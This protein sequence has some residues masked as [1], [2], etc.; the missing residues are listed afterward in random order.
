MRP[1]LPTL[2]LSMLTATATAEP[3]L[4]IY[5]ADGDALFAPGTAAL[6]EGH[7]IAHET[8]ALQLTGGRQTLVIDGL[9]VMLDSEAVAI[10]LGSAARVLAQRIIAPGDAG[11]LAAH[12]G[13]NVR[14]I[15]ADGQAIA[16]GTLVAL[17][18]A[19]LVVRAS[20]GRIHYVRDFA[21][22]EFA[23]GTGLPGSTL[24]VAVEGRAG[25]AT[26][27]LTYPTAGLGWRAAY[28]ALLE[29][30][31]SCRLQLDALA[32]IANRS[33]RDWSGANLKL[34][35]GSPNF[36]RPGF[37]PRPMMKAAMAAD[38]PEGLPAQSALGDYRSY[39]IG[40]SLDLP[41]ASI[42]QVPLYARSQR[43]C[44]RL[45]LVEQGSAWFPGK[46]MLTPTSGG[47]GRLPV[48]SRLTF[49]AQENL[50]AGTL[51]ALTRDRDGRTEFL[52]EARIADTPQGQE[53]DVSLGSAF[54]LSATREQ[55]AFEVD[56][57][58]RRLDEGVRYT[59]ANAGE[60]ART[61]TVRTHPNQWRNWTLV[62]S[63]EKPSQQ[64][65][66]LLEF[67][68]QVPAKGKATLDYAVRYT[69]TAADE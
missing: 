18:G 10:D 39:A 56:R 23:A 8:R 59:L 61:I 15:G 40:G 12:R 41:D 16:E 30:G 32:S 49:V 48:D 29:D 11:A 63:S 65:P 58:A 27:T 43:D 25:A 38:A 14:V 68:V 26:A 4:T 52:G 54:A 42:T 20:D 45:W 22:I 1:L 31:S 37:A 66:N 35:A 46:P 21:Q 62:S 64:R 60:Q 5:R 44:Q 57:A 3:A 33:G 7:A 2:A 13:E 34:I 17:D 9:P 50:P 36:A 69:W 47:D 67:K 24:Q 55:T 53:V 28:A 51:R 19:G 6:A